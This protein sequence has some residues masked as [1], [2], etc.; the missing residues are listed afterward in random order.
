MIDCHVHSNFST[1][2]KMP[3]E[4]ILKTSKDLNIGVTVTD[5][6]DLNYPD[7]E[8][9]RFDLNKYVEAYENFRNN[10]F[11]LGIE[12][13]M[14]EEIVD[15]NRSL[16]EKYRFDLIIGS[17]HMIDG[18]DIYDRK[19]YEGKSRKEVFQRYFTLMESAIRSH[20]YINVLAHIDYIS[21]YCPYEDK[22]IWYREF[23]DYIDEVL[24]RIIEKEIAFEINTRRLQLESARN[25][26]K[27]I[28]LR[29]KELGGEIVTLGSDAHNKESI[30]NNFSV[31][32]YLTECSNLKAVY[33]KEGKIK[34][35]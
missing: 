31:G 18:G 2:S 16:I 3:I 11:F 24:K 33:F 6:M 22:E 28:L 12:L 10:N 5:H 7:K 4:D 29:Y 17:I 21:R 9:F 20:E 19:T 32:K 23:S 26:I 35:L 27:D 13:G 15:D 34:S 25:N 30:G 8:L 14:G 1:D